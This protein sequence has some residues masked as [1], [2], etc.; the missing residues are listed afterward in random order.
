MVSEVE[1]MDFVEWYLKRWQYRDVGRDL[2][3][4]VAK[5]IKSGISEDRIMSEDERDICDEYFK[6]IGKSCS[7]N[8]VQKYR[9]AVRLFRDFRGVYDEC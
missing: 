5:M 9:Q 4:R 1:R 6:K 7:Y 3:N 2:Y 8:Y